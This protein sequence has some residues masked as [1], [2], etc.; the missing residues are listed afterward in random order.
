MAALSLAQSAYR[1]LYDIDHPRASAC[2]L[3]EGL[4]LSE[5]ARTSDAPPQMEQALT[6][7]KAPMALA[8][9]QF[10]YA[11][12]LFESGQLSK[13]LEQA[14]AALTARRAAFDVIDQPVFES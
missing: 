8:H 6:A 2:L 1:S 10:A 11:Q 13:A 5:M 7:L 14:I 3:L 12:V 9:G 4:V